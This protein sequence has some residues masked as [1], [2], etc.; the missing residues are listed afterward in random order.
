[1]IENKETD[2]Y[3]VLN[4]PRD[5]TPEEIGI[6]YRKMAI[7]YHPHR[8]KDSDNIY[9]PPE[10]ISEINHLPALPPCV[11]WAYVNRAYDVLSNPLR[12]EIYDRYGEA[13]LQNGVPLPHGFF[14]PYE[15]HGDYFKTYYEVFG[16]YSP[17]AD[18]I[19]AAVN[20]PPL[21]STDHGIGVKKKDPP[22]EKLLYLDLKEVFFG[23]V[24]RMQILRHEFVDA[25]KTITKI[26]EK[27]LVIPIAPGILPGT[28]ITFPEEG[29]QG[30]GRIPADIIFIIADRP[31]DIFYRRGSDLYMDYEIELKD[32]LCG[33]NLLINTIDERKLFI[34]ISDVIHPQYIREMKG[35][36]LPK[37]T[38]NEK[39]G[40]L[41]IR[42]DIKFPTLVPKTMKADVAKL[43]LQIREEEKKDN[44]VM[45]NRRMLGSL[46][47]QSLAFDEKEEYRNV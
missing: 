47:K 5:A 11:Q 45:A 2:F 3:A 29:D 10:G 46:K 19:E 42:F 13:G 9:N 35:E 1:M 41:Y 33:T 12:R 38:A 4:I 8:E 14:Q 27:F 6:A 24:K 17:Y 30:P 25:A 32:A 28:K 18:V 31:H 44:A 23:G 36:G 39:K 16:S 21:Y 34:S 20:P 26:R 37:P 40:N 15:Y 7:T 22:V 43:F